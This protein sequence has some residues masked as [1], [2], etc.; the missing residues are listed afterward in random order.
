M[1][2][3]DYYRQ[4][5]EQSPEEVSRELRERAAE[6]RRRALARVDPVDLS[7]TTWPE[8][9]PSVV[10]N[11]VTFV[12]RRGLQRLPD[13][14]ASELRSELAHALELPERRIVVGNGAAQLLGAAA[15]AL[16]APGDELLSPW[17]SSPLLPMLAR[18]ARASAAPVAGFGV[19]PI[20]GAVTERTRIV[21]LCNPND[22]TGAWLDADALQRLLRALPERV[23][24]LLDEALV[25]FAPASAV[26]LTSEF[27]RLLVF[28]SFSKAWGLAG[29]RVGYAV[30]GAD[31]EPLLERLAPELGVGEL[32]QAGALE[33]LRATGD[34]VARR[35]AAV[36]A[37]RDRLTGEL[38]ELGLDVA[39]S[40]ANLLWI[41]APGLA[42]AEL[43]HRLERAK[44]RVAD[45]ARFG[46]PARIRAAVQTRAT[47]DRLRDG[48][49]SAL[50]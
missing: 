20:V 47:S 13:P 50:R 14:T 33:A 5:E 46:D 8:L 12:A 29:L 40:H 7:T 15:T 44:V 2:L 30:G 1:G 11:A 34:H 23:V 26:A 3:L 36:A 35:A 31:S 17:P 32:A 42:G 41:A 49:V 9:P 45:S 4:F 27:P 24:V 48:I 6:R 39:A 18:R 21:A 16:L 25:E 37:E 19:E 38:R 43:A 22:P 10:V 28:R